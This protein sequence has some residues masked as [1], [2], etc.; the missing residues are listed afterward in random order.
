MTSSQKSCRFLLFWG[1]VDQFDLMLSKTLVEVGICTHR[2]LGFCKKVL[3]AILC[4]V[5]VPNETHIL[6]NWV[7]QK[8][9]YVESFLICSMLLTIMF[10]QLI[11]LSNYQTIYLLVVCCHESGIRLLFLFVSSVA[12]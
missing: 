12:L 11:E 8:K 10:F 6:K 7:Y 1:N 5:K 3:N 9:F 2:K 4:D